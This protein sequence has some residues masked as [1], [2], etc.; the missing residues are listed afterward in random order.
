MNA[1]VGSLNVDLTLETARFQKGLSGAQKQLN[2]FGA[3]MASIGKNLSIG[4]TAP[5]VAFG[6]TAV[7]AAAESKDALGQVDAALASMGNAAG[8]TSAQLQGLASGIMAKSLYD[9]DEILRKVSANMLT[10]G[11]ISG[12]NF[13]LAQQAAVDLAARLKMDL[14]PATLLVGKALND[15]VKG[16]AALSRAGIQFTDEQREQIKT[17][18]E[19]GDT[20]GAQTIL[21]RELGMQFGGSAEAARKAD[22]FAALRLSFGEFQEKV[23][24]E[25]LKAMP[26]ITGAIEGVLKAFNS[27]SPG[28]QQAAVIGGTLAV[29]LGPVLGAVGS[30]LPLVTKLGPVFKVLRIAMLAL[31]ANPALLA[32]AGVVAGIYLAWENW[33]TIV[34]TVKAV[35]QGVKT[36]L[37]DKLGAVFDWVSGKLK[38]FT[39]FFQDSYMA[40]VG[41][42]IVPDMV[43]EIGEHMRRLQANMVDPAEWAAGKTRDAFAKLD[44]DV[45]GIF[46]RLFPRAAEARRF[47]EEMAKIAKVA[48]PIQRALLERG[49]KR[50]QAGV[51]TEGR[52]PVPIELDVAA[53]SKPM[54]G[55]SKATDDLMERMAKL[56][57]RA[58]VT[59]V[60]VA[61]SFKDMADKTL[62]SISRLAGAIKGGG[63]LDILE[64]VIG[65]GVQL[66]S[67]GAFGKKIQ[68]RINAPAYATGTA[69]AARGLALVGERGPELVNF[70]GG[71]RVWSNRETRGMMG[72]GVQRVEIVDTTGLFRFR[73]GQQIVE[74]APAMMAGG[75]QVAQARMAY[76]QTRRVG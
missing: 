50:E 76:R 71:E 66:G 49:L 64:A 36:W 51:P 52:A 53:W 30:L 42:S 57:E 73:V 56:G 40:I 45:Q 18:A 28:M 1:K 32:L 75:A 22:P 16:M 54:E 23:G 27:L 14:Q 37:Q 8:R 69:R 19:A 20:I 72:G 12:K 26:A 4:L 38:A 15:P 46:D 43:D 11:N 24:A 74:A 63:F 62:D 13:E 5:L 70:R 41:N 2:S 29:A 33:D 59:T 58:K 9:D 3:K 17:M 61:E 67:I 21:L 35:Y 60:K 7:K 48:D 47:A 44:S 25:L 39:G 10:F 34:A 31:A 6:V 55:I 65:L 68:A